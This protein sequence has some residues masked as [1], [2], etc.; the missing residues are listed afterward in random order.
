MIYVPS[1]MK[2]DS[3]IQA[4]LRFSLSSVGGCNTSNI[5]VRDLRIASVRRALVP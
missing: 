5:D 3:A 4:I 1:F 2:I